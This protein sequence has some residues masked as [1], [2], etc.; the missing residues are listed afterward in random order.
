VLAV[1][2]VLPVVRSPASAEL[3][4]ASPAPADREQWW[5]RRLADAYAHLAAEWSRR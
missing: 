4:A 2:G 3:I 5:R 1:D